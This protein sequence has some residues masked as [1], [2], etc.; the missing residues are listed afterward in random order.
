MISALVFSKNNADTLCWCLPSV[1][2]S[3][4]QDKEVIVVDG[5]STDGTFEILKKYEGKI[6]VIG[7]S[8]KGLGNARN[9]GVEAASYDLIAC[10]DTDV[11]CE[12]YHFAKFQDYFEKHPEIGGLDTA[13]VHPVVGTKIQKLESL[14]YKAVE[15]NE[16]NPNCL[17]GWSLAFRREAFDKV[18]GFFYK[19]GEDVKF[20]YSLRVHGFKLGTV[21]TNSVHVPRRTIR[22]LIKEM[23][24]WGYNV[25]D[26]Y[27]EHDKDS[28]LIGDIYERK[29]AKILRLNSAKTINFL[30]YI[31]APLTGI[32]QTIRAKLLA[33]Y[34][35]YVT[36]QFAYVYGYVR[37]AIDKW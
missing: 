32:R 15:E 10:V 29:L 11:L 30:A 19:G 37:G 5:N 35:Y 22:E 33:M 1:I 25:A 4:P 20:S 8:G 28:L 24:S 3:E 12:K 26:F 31:S 7:D 16:P 2:N 14:L 17:R 27:R 34:P 9:V 21:P 36:R 6:R 13:G 23:E 18:G